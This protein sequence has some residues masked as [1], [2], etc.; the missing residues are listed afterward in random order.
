MQR[1]KKKYDYA[2]VNPADQEYEMRFMNRLRQKNA[3]E[4]AVWMDTD[5]SGPPIN[6]CVPRAI[7]LHDL[8]NEFQI[9]ADAVWKMNAHYF[10]IEDEHGYRGDFVIEAGTELK[11]P[12]NA[13]GVP[14]EH[15]SASEFS[16]PDVNKIPAGNGPVPLP[17]TD[18]KGEGKNKKVTLPR[19][20]GD[21]S[22]TDKGGVIS[23]H[24]QGK[25][26]F[27]N[28][29]KNV[30]SE[31]K[32]IVTPPAQIPHLQ[33]GS[34]QN[35]PVPFPE[36]NKKQE[37][38]KTKTNPLP[39]QSS[40]RSMDGDG[41]LQAHRR[42][43]AQ[44]ILLESKTEFNLEYNANPPV[45][46]KIHRDD[47][48]KKYWP[49][50]ADELFNANVGKETDGKLVPYKFDEISQI[51]TGRWEGEYFVVYGSAK[52]VDQPVKQDAPV[53]PTNGTGVSNPGSQTPVEEETFTVISSFEAHSY[54]TRYSGA[55]RPDIKP[56][57][58]LTEEQKIQYDWDATYKKFLDAPYHKGANPNTIAQWTRRALADGWTEPDPVPDM[59]AVYDVGIENGVRIIEAYSGD[60][61]F[62]HAYKM[63]A[64]DPSYNTFQWQRKLS[65]KRGYV[66]NPVMGSPEAGYNLMT[67]KGKKPEIDF[68]KLLEIAGP[69]GQGYYDVIA[70]QP[71]Y[72]DKIRQ[73]AFVSLT[74]L[75]Q[76][77]IAIDTNTYIEETGKYDDAVVQN[78]LINQEQKKKD[79]AE[80]NRKLSSLAEGIPVPGET[81]LRRFNIE[82]REVIVDTYVLENLQKRCARA[83]Y[84]DIRNQLNTYTFGPATERFRDLMYVLTSSERTTV[85]LAYSQCQFLWE[86]EEQ[87]VNQVLWNTPA[88]QK[89]NIKNFLAGYSYKYYYILKNLCENPE[90][91]K[92]FYAATGA[93]GIT[94]DDQKVMA[95]AVDWSNK[96]DI[97]TADNVMYKMSEQQINK[98]QWADRKSM[99]DNYMTDMGVM[100]A[101]SLDELI[102]TTP[103]ADHVNL[104]RYLLSNDEGHYSFDHL[105]RL[106][107][108]MSSSSWDNVQPYLDSFFADDFYAWWVLDYHVRNPDNDD[109]TLDNLA[110]NVPKS[111]VAKLTP[112]R[113][114][115]FIV[116]LVKAKPIDTYD[117]ASIIKI[118]E[119]VG[120]TFVKA[121]TQ[122][123]QA[124]VDGIDKDNYYFRKND[125][126]LTEQNSFYSSMANTKID[127]I[128]LLQMLH[129]GFQGDNS[130]RLEEIL[131]DMNPADSAQQLET[132]TTAPADE[133]DDRIAQMGNNAMAGLTLKDRK[134]LIL[135]ICGWVKVSSPVAGQDNKKI[136][137]QWWTQDVA[138]VLDRDEKSIIR[139]ISSTPDQEIISLFDWMSAGEGTVYDIIDSRIHGAEFS[140]LHDALLTKAITLQV[141]PEDPNAVQK[142]KAE[143]EIQGL[144]HRNKEGEQDVLPW[145]DHGILKQLAQRETVYDYDVRFNSKGEVEV[146]YE[147]EL[148][149]NSEDGLAWRDVKGATVA[150]KPYELIGVLF[151]ADDQ[152]LQAKKGELRI[153][154][155]VNLFELQN[156]QTKQHVMEAADVAA[157]VLSVGTLSSAVGAAKIVLACIDIALSAGGLI[158]SS[159]RKNMPNEIYYAWQAANMALGGYFGI[160]M[161][162]KGGVTLTRQFVKAGS[163]AEDLLETAAHA[164][165]KIGELKKVLLNTTDP[166]IIAAIN[167]EVKRMEAEVQLLRD[168]GQMQLDEITDLRK[169]VEENTNLTQEAKTA[170]LNAMDERQTALTGVSKT[171]VPAETPKSETPTAKISTPGEA[172]KTAQEIEWHIKQEYAVGSKETNKEVMKITYKNGKTM[173]FERLE[174][175]SWK[176]V[177]T[178]TPMDDLS[179]NLL[180]ELNKSDDAATKMRER[181]DKGGEAV[182]PNKTKTTDDAVKKS[183][184]APVPDPTTKT[185]VDAGGK[186]AQEIKDSIKTRIT[187][188]GE[189]FSLTYTEKELDEIIAKG[190]EL[191][192]D[193][194]T[195]EDFVV[196]GS[197]NK[198]PIAASE[199][200][201]QMTNY[202]NTVSKR[203]FPFLFNSLESFTNF[204]TELLE[205]LKSI[206]LPTDDV[207]LQGSSLRTES[208]KDLDIA[209][210]LTDEQFDQFLIKRFSENAT[211]NSKPLNLEGFTHKQLQ[212]LA[213]DIELNPSAYNAQAKGL[214]YAVQNGKLS[215]QY[216]PGLSRIKRELELT[217]GAMDISIMNS[218]T[219]FILEPSM[220]LK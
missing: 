220:K 101:D 182:P 191:G 66:Q 208:A 187:N 56:F 112:E 149:N 49:F 131:G 145:A 67:Y 23:P 7:K 216:I 48:R 198:K 89:E 60:D 79:E 141:S 58:R 122:P 185:P 63:K 147:I 16:F 94:I 219:N 203:G 15:Q 90:T 210:L 41:P 102:I 217:Y 47:M 117:E 134:E 18:T 59:Y 135:T 139:L 195:I 128:P 4:E 46:L 8:A 76:R 153:M 108:Q 204:K 121:E 126:A 173:Q 53:N 213:T 120:G 25:A 55:P 33:N 39:E 26:N 11:L 174:G 103:V 164:E 197:R 86:D 130:T 109:P 40:S 80:T 178:N 179:K 193:D 19:S 133:K 28:Y 73:E 183:D 160:T 31:G 214:K 150:F 144:A 175:E 166:E 104:R 14:E 157:M 95:S 82:G 51:P 194:K 68:A 92:D 215:G 71:T 154:A 119:T 44:D 34:P 148:P 27:R 38:Q 88:S 110:Y 22:G 84:E 167:A 181:V 111:V 142:L 218:K 30:K 69:D 180:D 2:R 61:A 161:L 159:Y 37:Q 118:L 170:L 78:Y 20:K 206:G 107:Q 188:L 163:A 189:E 93:L 123:G 192:L 207:R 200:M 177:D 172:N 116:E 62:A 114:L 87:I 70:A 45:L 97:N 211:K 176:P 156:K 168:I 152:D 17:Y 99:L 64:T 106:E 158:M 146:T 202:V 155:A 162:V 24:N 29:R 212:E 169:A 1:S 35:A 96:G 12:G 98:F 85:L 13:V 165:I 171:D 137:E 140:E 105:V 3:A 124:P 125:N 190:K 32:G 151:Y 65:H 81:F 83:Q 9:D 132:V 138:Y 199:L 75:V 10:G 205:K 77:K 184:D 50:F 74:K 129:D 52:K 91:R 6:Y 72:N 21:E 143:M 136:E 127:G 113:K 36:E 196:T 115:A 42:K 5:T 54:V 201:Q 57:T 100:Y 186:T 43:K 209:V